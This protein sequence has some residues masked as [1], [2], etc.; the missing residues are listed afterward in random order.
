MAK[1]KKRTKKARSVSLGTLAGLSPEAKRQLGDAGVMMETWREYFA[2]PGRVTAE[3]L[4]E[5]IRPL[6][7]KDMADV[8]KG[9]RRLD[10]PVAVLT[11]EKTTDQYLDVSR[12]LLRYASKLPAEVRRMAELGQLG[13]IKV[14]P[15]LRGMLRRKL[16]EDY[17]KFVSERPRFEIHADNYRV[18]DEARNWLRGTYEISERV[19]QRIADELQRPATQRRP[20]YVWELQGLQR[21]ISLYQ[22]LLKQTGAAV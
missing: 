8:N 15:Q 3:K 9:V 19:A 5:D 1:P 2:N 13:H 21:A 6:F 22:T 4:R 18:T 14:T 11:A 20:G 10:T 12:L 16:G 7:E 17:F